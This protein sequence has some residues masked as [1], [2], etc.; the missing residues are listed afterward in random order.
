MQS[1][2]TQSSRTFLQQLYDKVTTIQQHINTLSKPKITKSHS[3]TSLPNNRFISSE[4]KN[5][6][7]KLTTKLSI[8]SNSNKIKLDVYTTENNSIKDKRLTY[9]LYNII[10][11]LLTNRHF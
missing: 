1:K 6:I 9:K 8:N 10:L 11:L 5:E 3:N 7:N 4:I 2:L